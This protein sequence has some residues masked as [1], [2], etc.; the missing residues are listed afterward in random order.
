M[1]T[2]A[3]TDPMP[4]DVARLAWLIARY[5]LDEPYGPGQSPPP[6]PP[7]DFLAML[8]APHFGDC[9]NECATCPRC[10]A[11]YATAKATWLAGEWESASPG[12]ADDVGGHP[13][14]P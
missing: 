1:T 12:G 5:E 8:A 14:S 9:T 3:R 13:G 6:L 11:E 4:L 10:Y 2:D 7:A